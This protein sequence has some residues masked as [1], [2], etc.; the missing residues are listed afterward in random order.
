MLFVSPFQGSLLMG[1]GTQGVWAIIVL[2]LPGA[3]NPC[4]TKPP[5]HAP[6][7]DTTFGAQ[8]THARPSPMRNRLHRTT[9]F[10][11]NRRLSR[12]QKCP[13]LHDGSKDAPATFRAVSLKI[14]HEETWRGKVGGASLLPSDLDRFTPDRNYPGS[15][16]CCENNGQF[17]QK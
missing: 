12:R 13:T 10:M 6:A 4:A 2:P 1:L 15:K 11:R 9:G 14:C 8:S 7:H 5:P 3:I 16:L 17:V